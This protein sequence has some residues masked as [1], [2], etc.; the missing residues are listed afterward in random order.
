MSTPQRLIHTHKHATAS[1]EWSDHNN[2]V[3]S[4]GVLDQLPVN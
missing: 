4:R 1:A 3:V 2:L